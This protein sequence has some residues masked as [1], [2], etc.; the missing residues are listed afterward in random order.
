MLND[1]NYRPYIVVSE[2]VLVTNPK[3]SFKTKSFNDDRVETYRVPCIILGSLSQNRSLGKLGNLMFGLS[4]TLFQSIYLAH[5][6][7]LTLSL[8]LVKGINVLHAHNPPDLTGL[9]SFLVSRITGVPY[10]FEVHDRA[11][12]LYCG[13][14]GLP[15]SSI[16]YR[17]MKNI[18]R[19]VVLNSAGMITVNE[20]VADYYKSFGGPLPIA[21]YTGTYLNMKAIKEISFDN[22]KLAGKRVILYQGALNMASIGE[23][24][25][26]D[27]MLPLQAMPIILKDYPNAVLV[28]VGEGTGRSNLE[29]AAV[30]MG[31]KDKVIFTG[32]IPQKQVFEWVSRA[33]VALIPYADNP[34]CRTTVPSKL[35][36]YMALGKPIVATNFPGIYE[37]ID[38]ERNGLVYEVKSLK[39]FSECIMRVLG[40]S[41]FA[42]NIASNARQDFFSKY[43]LDKNWPRL[44]SLYDSITD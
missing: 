29:Q 33:D 12:E 7:L 2:P 41:Q 19:I 1:K 20:K 39:E 5:L 16:V 8:T 42:Q 24:A 43:S 32:F 34:N 27:L 10:V 37:I 31:I 17:L 38:N 40:N 13:E 6:T 14:M 28:Y 11:P 21:I 36:E 30:S 44:I 25:I 3:Q 23:P 35:Y 22:H 26:Y 9:V 18:E 15:K 4:Y